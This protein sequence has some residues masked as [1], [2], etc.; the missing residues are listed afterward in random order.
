MKKDFLIRALLGALI[1]LV[2]CITLYAFGTFD[3]IVVD[4]K[5]FVIRQFVGS[6]LLGFVAM[7]GTIV[8]NVERWSLNV[9]TVI[10]YLMTIAVFIL[11]CV[12][13]NW[14]PNKYLPIVILIFTG[15]YF[16]IWLIN[17]IIYKRSIRD[18]NSDLDELRKRED[19]DSCE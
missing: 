17:Y 13:L 2:I 1:G 11:D 10:H 14:F 9:V 16:I 7:G 15:A 12:F 6:A 4:N 18:I 8:Y 3:E 19:G 5:G